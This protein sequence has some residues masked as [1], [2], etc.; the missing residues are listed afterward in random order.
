MMFTY[1]KSEWAT[2]PLGNAC[3][4]EDM[5]TLILNVVMLEVTEGCSDALNRET[6]FFS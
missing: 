1:L 4:E 5:G 3:G 6:A 2:F